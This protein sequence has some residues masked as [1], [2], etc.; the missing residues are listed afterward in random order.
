M[1]GRQKDAAKLSR[2]E[3]LTALVAAGSGALASG[4]KAAEE[5]DPTAGP[6]N[7]ADGYRETAHIRAAYQ[8][9]RF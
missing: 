7:A 5:H 1:T 8:R 6:R 3:A 4:A 9:M 2:R